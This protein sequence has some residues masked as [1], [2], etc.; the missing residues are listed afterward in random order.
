MRSRS[1]DSDALEVAV[2]VGEGGNVCSPTRGR[3]TDG[4]SVSAQLEEG[5]DFA[6]PAGSSREVYPAAHDAMEDVSTRMQRR[7]AFASREVRCCARGQTQ[8]DSGR[9]V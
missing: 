1:C 6:S 8:P 2:A 9:M 3:A 7:F 5:T 4:S